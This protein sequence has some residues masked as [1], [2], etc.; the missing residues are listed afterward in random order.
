MIPNTHWSFLIFSA[1]FF[2]CTP[3]GTTGRELGM[4]FFCSK[5]I[6]LD[7]LDHGESEYA[8]KKFRKIYKTKGGTLLKW[9][10][11]PLWFLAKKNFF[12]FFS[13]KF[14]FHG[15]YFGHR[16][17]SNPWKFQPSGSNGVEASQNPTKSR[18]TSFSPPGNTRPPNNHKFQSLS[19]L[20]VS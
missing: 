11:S 13:R 10:G 6:F 7:V 2:L 18:Q 5:T 1:N 20:P 15:G 16:P 8:E 3:G 12:N 4:N 9:E 19:F 17:T 14:F